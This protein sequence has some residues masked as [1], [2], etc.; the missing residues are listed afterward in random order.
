MKK[1]IL[2]CLFLHPFIVKAQ[3]IEPKIS[4][5]NIR[6]SFLLFPFSPLLT[7]EARTLS[8]ITLQVET[9]FVN[10][11]GVNLKY[12]L[13]DRMDGHYLFV[14]TAFVENTLLRRDRKAAVL[15]YTGYGYAYRFG[16][17]KTWTFDS[18]LGIGTT[19][20]VDNNGIYPV[21][22]TGIGRTF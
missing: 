22:K 18:R 19:T 10:T 15:P 14:G 5:A 6:L 16:K 7:V 3:T 20:N 4:N 11:H 21:I 1:A 8:S 17:A 13:K 12:F 9:N 2:C